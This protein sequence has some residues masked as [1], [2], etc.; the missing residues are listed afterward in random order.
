MMDEVRRS[1]WRSD[2]TRHYRSGH[3]RRALVLM[4]ANTSDCGDVLK[5]ISRFCSEAAPWPEIEMRK[6]GTD[7]T[8]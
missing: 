5:M 4:A 8:L 2:I 1:V 7:K 6:G 3:Y